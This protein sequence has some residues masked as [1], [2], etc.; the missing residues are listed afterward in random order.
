MILVAIDLDDEPT[1]GPEKVDDEGTDPHVHPR[2]R[3]PMA[4]AEAQQFP[5]KRATGRR[6]VHQVVRGE[7]PCSGPVDSRLPVLTWKHA[8]EVE[9]RPG[10]S[11]DRNAMPTGDVV[12]RKRPGAMHGYPALPAELPGGG[13]GHVDRPCIPRQQLPQHGSTLVTQHGGSTTCLHCCEPASGPAQRGVANCVHATVEAVKST[14]LEAAMD[15][16]RREA[17]ADQLRRRE[18]AMI[19]AGE[20]RD[21]RV[22]PGRGSFLPHT[23][24]KAPRE[25]CRP[26]HPIR[27]H[28]R[29]VE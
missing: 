24:R 26:R 15:A 22:W 28:R 8:L 5:L 2:C 29:A 21:P 13:D 25:T 14:G 27:R 23:E 12:T 9:E 20:P 17:T 11:R 16:R 3:D 4:A 19:T 6:L 10:R 18:D 7:S 1:V